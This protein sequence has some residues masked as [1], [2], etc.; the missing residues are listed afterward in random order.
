MNLQKTFPF[1]L[2]SIVILVYVNILQN[3]FAY[4]DLTFIKNWPEIQNFQ[5]IPELLRGNLP[6][7]QQGVFRPLRSIFYTISYH[8]FGINPFG[9]HVQAIFIHLINTLLVYLIISLISKNKV[10]GLIS[11]ILFAIHPIHTEAISFTAASFDSIGI[12]FFFLAFYFYLKSGEKEDKARAFY[13]GSITYSFLAFIT[14]EMTLVLPI[15]IIIYDLLFKKLTLKKYLPLILAAVGYLT[16]RFFVYS[17]ISRADFMGETVLSAAKNARVEQASILLQYLQMLIFPQN[18][19]I[20]YLVPHN[21]LDVISGWGNG[22]ILEYLSFISPILPILFYGPLCFMAF[23]IFKKKPLIAFSLL[24]FLISLLPVA[25][26]IPQ[27][28]VMA[29]RYLYI[30]SFGFVLILA[31]F[32]Y[33]L[34]LLGKRWQLTK[35]FFTLTLSLFLTTSIFYSLT[36][37]FRNKEWK[38]SE[39]LWL[40]AVKVNP[41]IASI[42]AALALTYSQEGKSNLAIKEYKKAIA[43]NSQEVSIFNAL[44]Y[45]YQKKGD[46]DLAIQ[47]YKESLKIL[48][49]SKVALGNLALIY[50]AKNQDNLAVNY[51]LRAIEADPKDS[52]LHYRLALNYDRQSKY[53]EAIEEYKQTIKFNSLYAE[54]YNNLGII[55]AKLGNMDLAEQIFKLSL[56]INP[57]QSSPH[58]NLG[59]V[60]E[61]KSNLQLALEEYKKGLQIKQNKDIKQRIK[62]LTN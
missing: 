49:T 10:L 42:K 6:Q 21:F 43:L 26:I 24:W 19:T 4:D 51:Y 17:I 54:P 40:S 55:Y 8:F 31:Y 60:Y 57:N 58:F 62:K 7:D 37:Y 36:T 52:F 61:K 13:L 59:Q 27:G 11:G 22:Q 14:Y 18:L 23:V 30:P 34:F 56:E 44:A 9:Y 41:N 20:R 47:T 15:L 39:T 33:Q 38:N 12:I 28:S 16:I 48:P 5:N 1:L 25:S 45:E 32:F 29:E 2:A 53:K 3:D 35:I 46:F 50:E